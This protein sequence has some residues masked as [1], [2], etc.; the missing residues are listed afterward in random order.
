MEVKYIVPIL[1]NHIVSLLMLLNNPIHN[2]DITPQY[3]TPYITLVYITHIINLVHNPIHK[4]S[5][6]A[7][8]EVYELTIIIGFL[9]YVD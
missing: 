6:Y 4:P 9:F 5:I 8:L 1:Y 7:G 3:N 2:S